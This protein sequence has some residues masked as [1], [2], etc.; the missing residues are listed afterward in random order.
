MGKDILELKTKAE[1]D[2][3][4]K[5]NQFV[6]VDF[7]ATWCG[8]C[9]RI[10]PAY[11]AM[12]DDFPTVKFTQVDVDAN[13]VNSPSYCVYWCLPVEGSLGGDPLVAS[14][15]IIGVSLL[16]MSSRLL[17][18]I[19]VAPQETSAAQGVNCMPTFQFF[20]GGAKVDEL[21]GADEKA[22]REKI[23]NLIK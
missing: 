6:V 17:I 5:D 21:S 2:A 15:E 9:Q 22:V 18:Q 23:Q 1:F 13:E 3:T 11:H 14:S 10:K 8:P 20:K 4:I 7:T 19:S 16:V 12:A